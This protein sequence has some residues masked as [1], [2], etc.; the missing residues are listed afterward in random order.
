MQS[1]T[2]EVHRAHNPRVTRSKLVFAM[3][4]FLSIYIFAKHKINII[5]GASIGPLILCVV[6]KNRPLFLLETL[7]NCYVEVKANDAAE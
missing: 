4:D 6:Q 5:R 2:V 7:K 1:G 3:N